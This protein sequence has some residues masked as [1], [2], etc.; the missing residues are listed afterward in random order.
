MA[1]TLPRDYTPTST[2]QTD[3][4]KNQEPTRPTP[5]PHSITLIKEQGLGVQRNKK[6]PMFQKG[7]RREVNPFTSK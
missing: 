1:F 3:K 6:S 7:V 5:Y 2:S 4:Q